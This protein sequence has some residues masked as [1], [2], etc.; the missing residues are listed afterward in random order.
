MKGNREKEKNNV[1]KNKNGAANSKSKVGGRL[2]TQ[3]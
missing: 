1:K 3:R 2:H